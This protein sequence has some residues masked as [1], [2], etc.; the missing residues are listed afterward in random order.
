MNHELHEKVAH[1]EEYGAQIC[2]C[3]AIC[4]SCRDQLEA[5]AEEEGQRW[6]DLREREGEGKYF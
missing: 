4:Q 3:F 5:E 1:C 2:A 6:H